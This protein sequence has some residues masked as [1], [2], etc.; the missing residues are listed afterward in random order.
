MRGVAVAA[1]DMAKLAL[2]DRNSNISETDRAEL[3]ILTDK[4]KS[5]GKATWTFEVCSEMFTKMLAYYQMFGN[6]SAEEAA[7]VYLMKD[8]TL[9]KHVSALGK[10]LVDFKRMRMYSDLELP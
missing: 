4:D 5:I 1:Q 7:K 9:L 6:V 8:K 3:D 10:A 2:M